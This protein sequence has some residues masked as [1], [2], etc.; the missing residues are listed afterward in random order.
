MVCHGELALD[1]PDPTHLTEFFLWMSFGGVLGGLFN[2]LV[3]PLIFNSIVE[4]QLMMVVACLVLPAL[5][6]G[7]EGGWARWVDVALGGTI[8]LIGLVLLV[9]TFG[10]KLP[11]RKG[12]TI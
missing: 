8:L 9:V 3:A 11:D 2:G 5:G 7:A 10:D 4:Y 12:I 6:R 1:R